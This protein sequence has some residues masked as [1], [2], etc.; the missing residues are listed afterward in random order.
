MDKTILK[1]YLDAVLKFL[2]FTQKTY[3]SFNISSFWQN[4]WQ[5]KQSWHAFSIHQKVNESCFGYLTSNKMW[6]H[7]D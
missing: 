7:E 2:A 3:L 5:Q 1:Q 4:L 6:M